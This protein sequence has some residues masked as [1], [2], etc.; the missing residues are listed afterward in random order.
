MG[1]FLSGSEAHRDAIIVPEPDYLL[2][3]LPFYAKNKIYL[4]REDRFGSSVE[5][6]TAAA[7]R[8]SLGELL[9]VARSIKSRHGQS[10]LIV[11][12]HADVDKYQSGE[13]KF[14]YNKIFSWDTSESLD[15]KNSTTFVREF[16]AAYTDENYKIYS[17]R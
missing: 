2:E 6:T 17:V 12:G 4:T 1:E 11:L 13:T 14:S 10:V 3:S 16:G 15:F 7:R 8:L 9:T 5:L